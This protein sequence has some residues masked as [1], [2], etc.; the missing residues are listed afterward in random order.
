MLVY[1]LVGIDPYEQPGVHTIYKFK[2]YQDVCIFM[3]K[4]LEKEFDKNNY[5]KQKYVKDNFI[6]KYLEYFK[7][8]NYIHFTNNIIYQDHSNSYDYKWQLFKI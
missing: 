7:S 2:S 1:I 5:K 3:K 6:T 4:W 8:N